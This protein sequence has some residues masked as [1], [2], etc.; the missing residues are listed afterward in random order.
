MD[1]STYDKS[2]LTLLCP[3]IARNKGAELFNLALKYQMEDNDL[4]RAVI[5]YEEATKFGFT[6]AMVNL[7]SCLEKGSGI[8]CDLKKAHHYIQKAAY[9]GQ[10]VAQNK[11]GLYYENVEHDFENA[12]E[13]YNKAISGGNVDA[14][15]NL[16]S[17]YHMGRGVG[18]DIKKAIQ[19]YNDVIE[20]PE[21]QYNLALCYCEDNEFQDHKKAFTLFKKSH[22]KGYIDATYNLAYCYEKGLGTE[23]DMKCAFT[24]YE[25]AANSGNLHAK[26][27][28]AI[29]YERGI[30]VNKNLAKAIELF[31]QAANHGEPAAISN[32]ATYYEQGIV[33]KRDLDKAKKLREQIKSPK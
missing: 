7:A 11:L 1:L 16:A 27:N 8:A 14:K 22:D 15:N 4:S 32:L 18:K 31:Q 23:S 19:L 33:V 2:R 26:T 28:L 5:L 3:N 24:F 29:F 20:M 25:I 17:C 6:D 21:A 12:V 30:V 10:P 9:L 13:M